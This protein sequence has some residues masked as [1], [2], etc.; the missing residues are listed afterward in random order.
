VARRRGHRWLTGTAAATAAVACAA[1]LAPAAQAGH[2][3]ESIFQDDQQLIFSGPVRQAQALSDID[4]LGADT[5][6]A[7]VTWRRVAP[8]PRRRRR[9]RGFH[10]ADP[11]AY[12][13]AN[14]DAYDALVRGAA[15]RGMGVLL[16]PS[17]PDPDWASACRG[18]HVNRTTCRPR[19]SQFQAFVEALGRRYSGTYTDENGGGVLP[20]V[21]RW[22]VWNEPNQGGWL[23]PQFARRHGRTTRIS[24]SL[25][26]SLMRAAIRGL[27][28]SGHGSDQI[29]LGETSP[30]G[31][32]TGPLSSRP[33]P[34]VDFYK[35]LFCLSRPCGRFPRL[36]VT[37]ISH[38]PY[39]RGGSQPPRAASAPGEI[40]IAS[41]GRLKSLVDRAARRGRIPR[42][43]P[44]FYTEFGYQT[45][46]PDDLFGVTL[47]QQA[48]YLNE[49]DWM[50]W[51]DRRVAAVSQYELRDDQNLS[52]FQ[53]G[54]RFLNG[55]LKPSYDAYRLP[56]WVVRRGHSTIVW[57][58][59]RPAADGA[60]EHVDIQNAP[61]VKDA[62][63]TVATADTTNPKGF[64]RIRLPAR[65]GRWRL[66]WAP[67]TGGPAL[68][69]RE[70]RASRR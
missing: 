44:F 4:R 9:P 56:I 67:S 41:I 15:A 51:N 22:S 65:T 42:R 46:P 40:T 38:H 33:M 7:L 28:A 66:R 39:T 11:A 32:R 21:T 12:P 62:F 3:Q 16:S 63:Q 55:A 69:S 54:L 37:G 10:A 49:A 19:P 52:L 2:D 70:A 47:K 1:V 53:S 20:R 13:A 18:R 50:A 64:F 36:A 14:W 26:R 29:L 30:I 31:R 27:R 68:L 6:H 57:G 34:P 17:S 58:Q 23:T 59:V 25:Y 43:L 48:T 45:N 24:P 35:S 5:V 8:A 60:L 61:T